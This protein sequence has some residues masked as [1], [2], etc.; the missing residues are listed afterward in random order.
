M[1]YNYLPMTTFSL[2]TV[3]TMKLLMGF[4]CTLHFYTWKTTSFSCFIINHY[5]LSTACYLYCIVFAMFGNRSSSDCSAWHTSILENNFIRHKLSFHSSGPIFLFVFQIWS[6]IV[7][8]TTQIY[9]GNKNLGNEWF[10][11]GFH[12]PERMADGDITFYGE[13]RYSQHSCVRSCLRQN[14]LHNA[15]GIRKRVRVWIPKIVQVLRH[16]CKIT[17]NTKSTASEKKFYD[18][19]NNWIIEWLLLDLQS[20]EIEFLWFLFS[21]NVLKIDWKTK[22]TRFLLWFLSFRTANAEDKQPAAGLMLMHNVS[23]LFGIHISN[24]PINMEFKIN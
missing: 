3:L 19:T 23:V 24:A 9:D 8:H 10:F 22:W 7:I 6:L 5:S 1:S 15:Q 11:S 14:A 20:F 2:P 4:S 13:R 21:I 18:F 12:S 16:S 17:K